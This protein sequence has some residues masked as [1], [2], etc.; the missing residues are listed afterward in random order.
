VANFNALQGDWKVWQNTSDGK[1]Y[2]VRFVPG[3]DP[4]VPMIWDVSESQL[5]TL[6]GPGV[7]I[8]VDRKLDS[9]ALRRTGAI[10][11]G[12]RDELVES[13][14][15]PF[16]SWAN[17]VEA[18]AAVRPWLR[19]PEVLALIASAMLE[20][21]EPSQAEFEQT[22]WWQD[23]NDA[24]RK[25]LLL[26][27]SD[28]STANDLKRDNATTVADMLL[29][30]GVSNAGEGLVRFLSNQWTM[31]NWSESYLTSQINHLLD[32]GYARDRDLQ[33]W[34]KK[35][36]VDLDPNESARQRVTELARQWLG[37]RIG[38][39]SDDNIERW[40]QI[41]TSRADG[42]GEFVAHLQNR[43][44]ALFP[45]YKGQ[46]LTYEDLAAPWEALWSETLGERPDHMDGTMAKLIRTNDVEKA[47]QILRHKGFASGN[48]T[49]TN[50]FRRDLL[51]ELSQVQE[52]LDTGG[53]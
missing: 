46:A 24:Q 10:N 23:H 4:P 43:Q 31:G 13:Q 29:Q 17:A 18:Q 16:D 34:I 11:W 50:A 7:A 49:V 2:L 5:K 42:E 41:L 35:A 1:Y 44:A 26:R 6:F 3:L 39:L 14:E 27:E 8:K 53:L 32:P 28:P 52:P 36:G 21:R 12:T 33:K 40:A 25:W 15:D 48:K 20:G 45:E 51:S 30:A 9:D 38:T 37:P 22:Q 19:E 47:G